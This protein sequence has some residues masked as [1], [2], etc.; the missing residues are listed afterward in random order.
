MKDLFS[1]KQVKNAG[2]RERFLYQDHHPAIITR[3]LF[4]KANGKSYGG[5]IE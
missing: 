3:D 4:E 5:A 1:G 2:E